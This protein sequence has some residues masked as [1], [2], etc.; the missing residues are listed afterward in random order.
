MMN[1]IRSVVALGLILLPSCTSR[2][3]EA[4]NGGL[5]GTHKVERR[6]IASIGQIVTVNTAQKFVLM[7]VTNEAYAQRHSLYYIEQGDRQATL[8]P[9]GERLSRFLAADILNGEVE[10]GDPVIVN[11]KFGSTAEDTP[12]TPLSQPAPVQSQL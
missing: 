12:L 2:P 4:P 1:C 6:S 8:R 11:L 7:K 10:P 9:T 3:V 5:D